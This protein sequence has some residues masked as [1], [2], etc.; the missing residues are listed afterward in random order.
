MWYYFSGFKSP[1]QA[2]SGIFFSDT[3][4]VAEKLH[5]GIAH[6]DNTL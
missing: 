5:E 2:F 1:E 4:H 6:S 3:E